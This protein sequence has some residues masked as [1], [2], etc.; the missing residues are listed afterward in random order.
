MH[1]SYTRYKNRA[2]RSGA[3]LTRSGLVPSKP[4]RTRREPFSP[5]SGYP[6]S[7][8]YSTEDWINPGA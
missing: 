3:V 4:L 6:A 5:G 7:P 8:A 2:V 1:T